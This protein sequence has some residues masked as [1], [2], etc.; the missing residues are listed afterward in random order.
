MVPGIRTV[1]IPGGQAEVPVTKGALES[2]L[3]VVILK[4]VE[5]YRQG[6]LDHFLQ[7]RSLLPLC[8]TPTS[9]RTAWDLRSQI[10]SFHDAEAILSQGGQLIPHNSDSRLLQCIQQGV[11]LSPQRRLV[12]AV[13]HSEGN[14]EDELNAMGQFKYQPPKDATGMLRYRWCEYLSESLG[15]PYVLLAVTWFEYKMSDDLKQVFVVTP[16]K[17]IEC[18]SAKNDLNAQFSAPLRLQLITRTEAN[19]TINLLLA[20]SESNVEIEIRTELPDRLA[21]EWSYERVNNSSKGRAL[22]KWAQAAGRLCPHCGK[23]LIDIQLSH[24]A[25]GHI[26]SRNWCNAFTF[27]LDRVNHPDNL[28]LT[29]RS[30]NSRLGDSFP[31]KELRD[32]IVASGTVGDMIRGNEA[33]IRE[34]S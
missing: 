9:F 15:V 23:Q 24:I 17:I 6:L 10:L 2:G 29:C 20:L 22:K 3:R 14:Y 34:I 12:L 4:D 11:E 32:S 30:C 31:S 25:Y 5:A 7:L 26:V 21:R 27:L 16:A 13:R 8:S 19:S 1:E 28:Y 33:E 18:D